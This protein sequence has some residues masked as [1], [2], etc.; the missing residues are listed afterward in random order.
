MRNITGTCLI[1]TKSNL[2]CSQS[3]ARLAGKPPNPK[4]KMKSHHSKTLLAGVALAGLMS[5]SALRLHAAT[6]NTT[7]ALSNAASAGALADTTLAD[8]HS[9][10]GQNACKG[11]GNCKTGDNGC[12]GKNDCKG[13]GGCKSTT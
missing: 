13:K 5:G 7:A 6:P 11:Q 4:K 9:C 10:K 8:A 2:A 3:H 12:K 1:L